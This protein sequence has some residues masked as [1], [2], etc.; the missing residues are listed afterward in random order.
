MKFNKIAALSTATVLASS[1]LFSGVALADN[2][3]EASP[4]ET[5]TPV[6]TKL[7]LP[8]DGGTNEQPENPTEPGTSE[9]T[10]EDGN[11]PNN[12]TGPFGIAYQPDLWQTENAE[13]TGV[14]L[15][16]SGA[17][18]IA[19]TNTNSDVGVK[20]KTRQDFAWDLKAELTWDNELTGATITT[21]NST[22][23]VDINK[24]DEGYEE[25][26]K[27]AGVSN[28]T[29]NDT[30]TEVMH[31]NTVQHNATYDYKLTNPTL[32][33]ADAGAVEEGTYTGTVTWTLSKAEA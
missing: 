31:G 3:Y 6:K 10:D 9:G 2:T 15:Q 5:E 14:T 23:E 17:Q 19:F 29:I 16:E 11:H 21:S 32:H 4:D 33:I 30:N 1:L 18:D 12:P 8:T 25:T 13:T 26:D 22:G 28:I 24:G 20:D 27:V 7:V